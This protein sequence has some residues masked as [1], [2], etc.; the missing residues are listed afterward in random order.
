MK[1]KSKRKDK[2]WIWYAKNAVILI[3]KKGIPLGNKIKIP[4]QKE[5]ALKN[6]AIASLARDVI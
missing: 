1:Y 4:I 3:N 6:P 5:I 2:T